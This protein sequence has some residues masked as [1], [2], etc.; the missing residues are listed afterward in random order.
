MIETNLKVEE[1]CHHCNAFEPEYS[2]TELY[3][4]DGI[5]THLITVSCVNESICSQLMDYLSKHTENHTVTESQVKVDNYNK[6]LALFDYCSAKED[7]SGCIFESYADCSFNTM[8]ANCIQSLYLK[9]MKETKKN[10]S[11]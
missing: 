2:H 5:Y 7:C 8:T 9:L 6:R 4:V 11:K 1:R 10:E 3:T